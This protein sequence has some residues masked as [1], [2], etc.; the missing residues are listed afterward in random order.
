M[1][2]YPA[3]L[4]L[5]G[6]YSVIYGSEALAV[7]INEYYGEWIL[8]GEVSYASHSLTGLYLYLAKVNLKSLDLRKLKSDIDNGLYFKSNIPVGYGLGSSG[9]L[10]AGILDRYKTGEV[11]DWDPKQIQ[12]EL[13]QIESFF[14]GKSSGLDPLISYY[15]KAILVNSSGVLEVLED[16]VTPNRLYVYLID[17]GMPRKT[18]SLVNAFVAKIQEGNKLV[19]LK[20]DYI[21][22]VNKCIEGWLSGKPNLLS[23][24][25]ELSRFQLNYF[26]DYIPD[27]IL[28][29]WTELM[30]NNDAAVKL[31]GAGG[32]GFFLLFSDKIIENS[33][34]PNLKRII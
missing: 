33:R 32:G 1:N 18:E 8:N 11:A 28:K 15:N 4:L 25:K 24:I 21:P 31:C 26:A 19:E 34:G 30:Q 7:P 29:M 14:H 23:D 16:A 20:R 5:F 6:E 10:C 27:N 12:K 3:K 22:L 2:H 9:S 17:S 13:G